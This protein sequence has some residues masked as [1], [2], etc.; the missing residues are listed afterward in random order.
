MTEKIGINSNELA[1]VSLNSPKNNWSDYDYY[2]ST[3]EKQC[4][5]CFGDEE[6]DRKSGVPSNWMSPC[7]VGCL[8]GFIYL[9]I[10]FIF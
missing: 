5:F 10:L 9:I 4:R 3:D 6:L 2:A 7:K 1:E 8:F